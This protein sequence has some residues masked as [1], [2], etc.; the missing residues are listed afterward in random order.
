M[1][2]TVIWIL[3]V[4]LLSLGVYKITMDVRRKESGGLSAK[5]G[6][7]LFLAI[8]V[9][10]IADL[11]CS[12]EDKMKNEG[13]ESVEIE[14]QLT[15]EEAREKS[16]RSQLQ[17]YIGKLNDTDKPQVKL[18][19]EQGLEHRMNQEYDEAL[20]IF[21]QA[22]DLK[23]YDHERLAFFILMGN[24]EAY[25][26]E[27]DSA[28]NYYFQA[29]RLGQ[30]TGNDTALAVV[31]SN[32]ALAYQLEEE[33]DGALDNYFNLLKLFRKTGNVQGERNALANIGFIY[34]IKGNVDSASVYHKK[35]LEVPGTELSILA[36]AAQ[37][38]NLAL[39]YRSRGKLDSA[40]T[41]HGQAW[42]LFQKAGDKKNEA[43]VLTNI[44]LIYQEMGDLTKAVQYHRQAFEIDSTMG[45]M[46]GQASDLTNM[47][48]VLEQEGN[49]SSAKEYYQRA[50][51]LFEKV[52]A[53][54]EMEFVRNNIR[55]VEQKLKE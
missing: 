21:K 42:M 1:W 41:L 4:L 6:I 8:M 17:D 37:M 31:Y 52:E 38:N 40:L 22:L 30:D 10:L 26:K 20:E 9:F 12:K 48:S 5:R 25:L 32:L 19:L 11:R 16:L 51:T 2:S 54:R 34:Q 28:I 44:G 55:R 50:L 43:S 53:R 46:M 39:T 33:P 18:F 23:L 13:S 29:E 15:E 24:C 47:G 36:Q 35:S 45:D 27:Y 3:I 14:P 7:V 49:L